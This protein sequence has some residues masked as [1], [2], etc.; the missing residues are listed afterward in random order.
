MSCHV[1]DHPFIA[2][3]FTFFV[4][5]CLSIVGD[6]ALALLV[7]ED[8]DRDALDDSNDIMVA[9]VLKEFFMNFKLCNQSNSYWSSIGVSFPSSALAS[10]MSERD[11]SERT[12]F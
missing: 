12:N 9:N 6:K 10:V 7:G 8:E 11:D 4:G 3:V 2:E 1:L 5:R